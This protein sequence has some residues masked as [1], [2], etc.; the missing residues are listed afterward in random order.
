M[1]ADDHVDF[2]KWISFFDSEVVYFSNTILAAVLRDIADEIADRERE[3][4]NK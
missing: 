4:E 3:N 2:S 1:N